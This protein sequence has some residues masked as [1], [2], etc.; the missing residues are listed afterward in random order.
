MEKAILKDERQIK[1]TLYLR[2]R[3]CIQMN[4]TLRIPI[5]KNQSHREEFYRL[6]KHYSFRI[7]L[8]D[9]LRHKDCFRLT[10]LKNI[11][12]IFANGV[13]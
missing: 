6:L 12:D 13:F 11:S 5:P 8:R 10:Q 1:K 2:K 7:F 3:Q 9:I 4:P